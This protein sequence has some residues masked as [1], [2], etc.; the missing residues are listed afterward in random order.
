MLAISHRTNLRRYPREA[1]F[2]LIYEGERRRAIDPYQ[3]VDKTIINH[4]PE[5]EPVEMHEPEPVSLI[6]KDPKLTR[7]LEAVEAERKRELEWSR[8]ERIEEA[9]RKWRT[10]SAGTGNSAFWHLGIDLA[11]AGIG[12]QDIERILHVEAGNAHGHR[13][14]QD[15]SS[16]I[17]NIVRKLNHGARAPEKV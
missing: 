12:P 14:R 8:T 4:Q 5:P 9:V 2:F 17:K 1:S 7:F 11:R 6:R 15:R 3:W 13:S 10:H 16:D